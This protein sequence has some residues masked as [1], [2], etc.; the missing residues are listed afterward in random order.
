MKWTQ[1]DIEILKNNY[2]DKDII[3]LSKIL[4]R[5]ENSIRVRASEL[6][7]KKYNKWTSEEIE[8]LKKEYVYNKTENIV[9]LL[10][11]HSLGSIDKK[12]K[13]VGIKRQ[14]IKK[15]KW[16]IE[17]LKQ[18]KTMFENNYSLKRIGITL[19]R[20]SCSINI[21]RRKLGIL[22]GKDKWT[23]EE[24]NILKNYYSIMTNR[25][26]KKNFL[27]N[28]TLSSIGTKIRLI[29]LV[30]PKSLLWANEE[31]EILKDKYSNSTI[32]ELLKILPNKSKI[33]I[34]KKA[35][36]MKL[37]KNEET[38][39]RCFNVNKM[40]TNLGKR[41]SWRGKILRRD[42]K[43]CQECNKKYKAIELHAHH[44][45][46]LRI[47]ASRELDINNGICLCIECHKK[48]SK[49]EY[50]YKNKFQSAI[51]DKNEF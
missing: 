19:G 7:L 35:K 49:D 22:F 38:L 15:P 40:P 45:V 26:I 12:A 51:G 48:V 33:Q 46:P 18:L 9:K 13:E 42:G 8:I 2:F 24:I 34:N 3:Q 17:E 41:S 47:D 23:E 25:D 4:N 14:N 31:I 11:K 21:K 28:R 1:K 10:S 16:S 43:V 36:R 29:G 27:N 50:R 6:N 39:L 30:K 20:S 5:P 37:T 32:Q 44:I